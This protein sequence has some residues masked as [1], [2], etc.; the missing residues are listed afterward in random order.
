MNAH[1]FR[2]D[3]FLVLQYHRTKKRFDKLNLRFKRRLSNQS[4][5]ELNGR[6]RYYL[7]RKL[8]KLKSR[9]DE[10][11]ARLKM[12]IA[13]G[14]VA[15]SVLIST[16]LQAQTGATVSEGSAVRVNAASNGEQDEMSFDVMDDGRMLVVWKDEEQGKVLGRWYDQDRIAD[17]NTIE[18]ATDISGS[19]DVEYN[20]PQVAVDSDGSFVVVMD[21]YNDLGEGAHENRVLVLPF[22]LDGVAQ[23][24]DQVLLEGDDDSPSTANE[25][26]LPK[27]AMNG[28]GDFVVTWQ[29]IKDG[30]Y[31]QYD[32]FARAYI[33]GAWQAEQQ[34]SDPEADT[35]AKSPQVAINDD[36]DFV[37]VWAQDEGYSGSF[38]D[39]LFSI[40]YRSSFGGTLGTEQTVHSGSYTSGI[41]PQVHLDKTGEFVI[42]FVENYSYPDRIYARRYDSDDNQIQSFD[43]SSGGSIS[44][45]QLD[46]EVDK[47]GIHNFVGN[48]GSSV[49][50]YR[51]DKFGE[52]IDDYS[53]TLNDVNSVQV[54]VDGGDVITG[55]N[56]SGDP[57]V[58][59]V[60]F[61]VY[62]GDNGL[63]ADSRD[64]LTINDASNQELPQ[65]MHISNAA[66]DG[67]FVVAWQSSN[68][69]ESETQIFAQ[70]FNGD[71]EKVGDNFIV[72]VETNTFTDSAPKVAMDDDGK[73]V[74]GWL[75]YYESDKI[76]LRLYN[77]EG[78]PQGNEFQAADLE[79]RGGVD[80]YDIAYKNGIGAVFYDGSGMIVNKFNSAGTVSQNIEAHNSGSATPPK[81]AMDQDGDAMLIWTESGYLH[82]AV[83]AATEFPEG[84]ST[85]VE[86]TFQISEGSISSSDPDVSAF[87]DDDFIIAWNEGGNL[88]FRTSEDSEFKS[89][90][91]IEY[92]SSGFDI[93]SINY[94]GG[95]IFMAIA[96][97]IL[98]TDEYGR[99][100]ISFI[101]YQYDADDFQVVSTGSKKFMAGISS[102]LDD[103]L[104]LGEFVYNGPFEPNG[105]IVN[106]TST[107]YQVNPHVSRNGDG[108]YV[109]VWESQFTNGSSIYAKRYDSENC[110]VGSE[111]LVAEPD[112]A[113]DED[114]QRHPNVTL[115]EDGSFV[116]VWESVGMPEE[117]GG[118]QELVFQKF[119]NNGNTVGSRTPIVELGEDATTVYSIWPDI[120][121]D[122][123]GDFVVAW[124]I[125]SYNSGDY[126]N[127]SLRYRR[128]N[129]D[130][131]ASDE[132]RTLISTLPL[133]NE[134]SEGLVHVDMDAEGDFAFSWADYDENGYMNVR[135][136]NFDGTPAW[137]SV[138]SKAL[139]SAIIGND[140]TILPNG[141]V[142]AISVLDSDSG[143]GTDYDIQG[144]LFD[145]EGDEIVE[146]DF[147]DF[148]DFRRP[149]GGISIESNENEIVV[150]GTYDGEGY[151]VNLA[152]FDADG[153]RLGSTVY[154]PDASSF[155]FR[156][157][158]NT[159]VDKDGDIIITWSMPGDEDTEIFAHEQLSPLP[160][161]KYD[162]LNVQEAG[163]IKLSDEIEIF[164]NF[165]GESWKIAVTSPGSNGTLTLGESVTLSEGSK[166]TGDDVGEY[167]VY[168]KHNGTETSSDEFSLTIK[169][170]Y[171]FERNLTIP[172]GITNTNDN[173]VLVSALE[174]KETNE[175]AAL[176]LAI[177]SEK[178]SDEETSD[179]TYTAK[180]EDGGDLPAW[181]SFTESSITF[182]GTPANAD[183]AELNIRLTAADA[184]NL[185]VSDVFKLTIKNVNDAPNV[186]T[187]IDDKDTNEDA[188][189]SFV[190]EN[191]F[192][193]ID[194]GDEVTITVKQEDGSDL[195]G[196]LSYDA[197]T[198]QFSGTPL[199]ENVGTVF[200]KLT[201]TD[202]EGATAEEIF[203]INVINTNDAPTLT[204][205]IGDQTAKVGEAFELTIDKGAVFSDV[206][207]DNLTLS[208]STSDGA[209]I[210]DWLSFNA[211]TNVLSGVPTEEG[212]DI[213]RVTATDPSGASIGTVFILEV[214][215]GDSQD[216][217]PDPEPE[218]LGLEEGEI[219]IF[220]NPVVDQLQLH[221]GSTED[222]KVQVMNYSGQIMLEAIQRPG[223]A[224]DVSVLP[225]GNYLLKIGDEKALITFKFVKHRNN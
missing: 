23:T 50:F 75:Q 55:W 197:G 45:T 159:G 44:L 143:P 80:F 160:Q 102:S 37:I 56:N 144:V 128:Y 171:G 153:N 48:S 65:Q 67:S 22:S 10:L 225:A 145:P 188:L 209:A 46:M 81:I 164:D 43:F 202:K 114:Y 32:V 76:M 49:E 206:D 16:D 92:N 72:N 85:T 132:T 175:D 124:S 125:E 161:I 137:G 117:G 31:F 91:D 157:I 219:K 20:T 178:F 6:K 95:E 149:G 126:D 214:G 103:E 77:A 185:Q 154:V 15:A 87:G 107:N 162:D 195:P 84:S 168:Y 158:P 1:H 208:M 187:A 86:T 96:D 73:F 47:D 147:A 83:L 167:G 196:W 140:V 2:K 150:S 116:V 134:V 82:G 120:S 211:E 89:V 200:I 173:P 113:Y 166:F 25:A 4:L 12:A 42:G 205:S 39:N 93:K 51:Y 221:W 108:D 130:G 222:M 99:E 26:T 66:E 129:S 131:S 36:D 94:Q 207:G 127:A 8:R 217:D 135:K 172:I 79:G 169:S 204:G 104:G 201:G 155:D 101:D 61:R 174:D 110:Q 3:S 182:S 111:I 216:P 105:R 27:I 138:K 213:L 41:L 179:L 19:T 115:N 141:R 218:P 18:I 142:A 109:I 52:N 194:V 203:A 88:K 163:T 170:Q 119:D 7:L 71:G 106:S 199:N 192:E 57:D 30:S 181:L 198:G 64:L 98:T 224:L 121:S 133:P 90:K 190:A 193:D 176:S 54:R 78:V 139:N 70:R 21:V 40:R 60:Y 28:D 191:V 156:G 212:N 69:G 123:D 146:V 112:E 35:N 5:D 223:D 118:H 97:R 180:L 14:T 63:R 210:P 122:K 152:R 136:Y 38:G 53:N 62:S 220:P 9:L 186:L 24:G 74:I 215:P 59:S 183:V 165:G 17:E 29:S 13:A 189:F 11:T 148:M 184:G 68:D 100:R 151:S 34:L 177:S 33:N 58:S